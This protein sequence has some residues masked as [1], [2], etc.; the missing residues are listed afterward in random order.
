[1][2]KRKNQ[3]LIQDALDVTL[4]GLQDDPWLAQRVIA[5][6]Q[7]GEKPR[8][9]SV[10]LVLALILILGTAAAFAMA[11]VSGLVRLQR[12]EVGTMRDCVS[13]G[14]TLYL[15]S[16]SGLSTWMPGG[17]VLKTLVSTDELRKEGISFESLLYLD[18]NFI[19]LLDVENRK[20]WRYRDGE[21]TLLLD[22]RDT[23]MDIPYLRWEKAVCQGESLYLL[24][25]SSIEV[26]GNLLLY[27]TDL[28]TGEAEQLS[29]AEGNVM[30]LCDYE[31]GKILLLI[32][33]TEQELIL[34][35]DTAT[36]SVCE[37]LYISP[38]QQVQGL[39][40]SEEQGGLFALVR[41]VLSRWDGMK[42]IDLNT[43]A[44]SFL[45]QSF[46]IVDG[47]YVS[48]S[49]DEMQYLP[50]SSEDRPPSLTIRGMMAIDDADADFQNINGVAVTRYRDPA[51]TA[52]DVREAIE[53]GDTTDLFLLRMDADVIRLMDD[54]LAAPLG[55]S[56]ILNADTQTMTPLIRDALLVHDIP[57]A[58]AYLVTPMVWQGDY[59]I[60]S[61]YTELLVQVN[62]GR[63]S[64]A[65]EGGESWTKMQYANALLEGFISE[66]AR[67]NETIDFHTES[68]ANALLA[69]NELILPSD[70]E[71]VATKRVNPAKV[72]SL[73]GDFPSD[74]P[75]RGKRNYEL[76]KEYAD[77]PQWLLPP[78][79][80]AKAS[81]SVP[82][83][84]TIYLLN[85]NAQNPQAAIAYL[86]YVATHRDPG[87]EGLMKP[88][89]AEP[90]LHPAVQREL[91]EH[92]EI[93]GENTETSA[94]TMVALDNYEA[95]LRAVPD[96]WAITGERLDIYRNTILPYLDL[97]LHPLFS[98]SARGNGGIYDLLLQTV[99]DYVG[100]N[101]TLAE[102]LD[103]L[104]NIASV[105]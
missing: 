37:T 36:D 53:A 70:Q 96:S 38:I 92:R 33:D 67:D 19:G 41:G 42:W 87:D 54:G 102:C 2:N 51:L 49:F 10:V 82:A 22:Y 5:E 21:W 94:P 93:F 81:S 9:I 47:G 95:A 103:R 101:G 73:G 28:S 105:Q 86:E 8:R 97:K 24:G 83:R 39:A 15:I 46:A 99:L 91:D 90:V 75:Q 29:V 78:T 17:D 11:A 57:Y 52:Q 77:E 16:S 55:S 32:N 64:L 50:F 44:H 48:V 45:A 4:S 20:I 18:G 12:A 14:D 88:D 56:D 63:I 23:E 89:L 100:G 40:Y 98:A 66:S 3:E 25:R 1:M 34:V 43:S 30:E 79:V 69:L 31:P 60:P 35:L 27:R 104:Q 59:A 58:M 76:S 6:A 80:V 7:N 65:Y 74:L 71:S 68:F 61:T 13:T 72:L 62:S 26:A 84:L 85:K